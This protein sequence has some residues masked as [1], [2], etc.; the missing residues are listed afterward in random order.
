[1]HWA[2]LGRFLLPAPVLIA[3]LDLFSVVSFIPFDLGSRSGGLKYIWP[4][5]EW[6]SRSG[7]LSCLGATSTKLLSPVFVCCRLG[8]LVL[9][10]DFLAVFFVTALWLLSIV[11]VAYKP[12]LR[13]IKYC[14]RWNMRK[15]MIGRN[16]SEFKKPKIKILSQSFDLDL[17]WKAWWPWFE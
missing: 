8:K 13:K 17:Y 4:L 15:Q 10:V 6:G 9:V 1:M 7:E 14:S 3:A 5:G 2:V 11:L 12:R 16:E